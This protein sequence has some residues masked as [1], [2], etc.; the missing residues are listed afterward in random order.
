MFVCS[1]LARRA[2]LA[3]TLFSAMLL[4]AALAEAQN[5]PVSLL[6]AAVAD[7]SR[8]S[9]LDQAVLEALGSLRVFSLFKLLIRQIECIPICLNMI[10]PNIKKHT[11]CI[12]TSSYA[13][14]SSRYCI[15]T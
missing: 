9:L 1:I 7:A 5:E 11:L 8:L 4:E 2:Q 3:P 6:D 12:S 13:E 15:P 14:E 10:T